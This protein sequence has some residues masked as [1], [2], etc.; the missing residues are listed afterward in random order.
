MSYYI[1]LYCI[2][3]YSIVLCLTKQYCIVMYCIISISHRTREP[4]SIYSTMRYYIVLYY[5]L[6]YNTVWYL[7]YYLISFRTL[8]YKIFIFNEIFLAWYICITSDLYCAIRYRILLYLPVWYFTLLS[9]I[10]LLC[11]V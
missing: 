6:S 11:I 5:T 10:V 4:S 1:E 9:G 8:S 7:L 2:L 3:P